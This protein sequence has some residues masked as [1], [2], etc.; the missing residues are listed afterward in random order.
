MLHP[1][2]TITTSGPWR[3]ALAGLR[4][5]F[6]ENF[7]DSNSETE[8]GYFCF[9]LPFCQFLVNFLMKK[10]TLGGD[11]EIALLG[12]RINQNCRLFTTKD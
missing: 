3:Q 1:P 9:V 10:A 12:G 6:W 7:V 11:V 4:I 5:S 2:S 8:F